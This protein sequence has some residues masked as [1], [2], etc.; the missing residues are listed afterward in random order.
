MQTDIVFIVFAIVIQREV[1]LQR[2]AHI[3]KQPWKDL[4]ELLRI[5]LVKGKKEREE[6]KRRDSGALYFTHGQR[7][8]GW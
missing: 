7:R 1:Q 2:F 5:L 4:G 3:V 8:A 6:Q